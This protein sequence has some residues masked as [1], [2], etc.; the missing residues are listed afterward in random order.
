MYKTK[1]L[2]L[3]GRMM[4]ALID[5]DKYDLVRVICYATLECNRVVGYY[6]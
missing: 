6:F 2:G 4:H 3:V 1:F 5:T